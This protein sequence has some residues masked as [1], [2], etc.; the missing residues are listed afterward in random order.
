ME[1]LS[2]KKLPRGEQWTYELKLDELAGRKQ[3][4]NITMHTEVSAGNHANSLGNRDIAKRTVAL[5]R[6]NTEGHSPFL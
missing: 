6:E 3:R 5:N 1:C 4:L 2:A